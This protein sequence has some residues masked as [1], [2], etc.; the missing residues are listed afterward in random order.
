MLEIPLFAIFE[1][2]SQIRENALI[3]SSLIWS[4]HCN[5]KK[6]K[7]FEKTP[8]K[9]QHFRTSNWQLIGYLATNLIKLVTVKISGEL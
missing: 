7:V 9:S 6:L 1:I 4:I 5:T 2:S 8:R 3:W